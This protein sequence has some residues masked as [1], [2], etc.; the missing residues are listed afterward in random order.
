MYRGTTKSFTVQ[1]SEDISAAAI[2]SAYLSFAQDGEMCLDVA[3]A[4]MTVDTAN[5]RVTATLTQAQTLA[6]TAGTVLYYQF[7]CVA[8]GEAFASPKYSEPV[9]D[10][11][12]D[13][14]I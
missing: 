12:K 13:G 10:I 5:N 4:D 11:I 14:E 1:L 8:D 7:R 2:T 6:F 3:L 9:N